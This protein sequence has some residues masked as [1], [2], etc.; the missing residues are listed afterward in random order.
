MVV[1]L[2]SRLKT[3]Q[4]ISFFS[5]WYDHQYFRS[6]E[7][8]DTNT[9]TWS[10]E[11]DMKIAR[12]GHGLVSLDGKLFAI[13]GFHLLDVDMFEVY[14]PKTDTWSL[15]QHKLGGNISY[16]GACVIIKSLL[17]KIKTNYLHNNE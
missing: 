12:R 3:F 7:C 15:L 10:Q 14:D 4:I 17:L 6:M 2:L 8:Y 13:G 9:K 5:G 1:E 16:N 11:A